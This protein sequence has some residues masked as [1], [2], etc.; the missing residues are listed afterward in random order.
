MKIGITEYGDAGLDFRWENKLSSVDGAVLITK[1][2]NQTFMNKVLAHKEVP[3][4]IHCTCTGW[5]G[6]ILEL[7]VPDYKTQLDNLRK[8]IDAG[9][10][11][12]RVVLRID[13]IF[14]AKE[15][16]EHVH[17]ML[18]YFRSLGL[19]EDKIRYRMSIVDEYNHVK[20]RYYRLGIRPLYPGFQASLAQR[21]MVAK[22]L[23]KYPYRFGTCAEDYLAKNYPDTFYVSGCISQE[24]LNLMGISA[25]ESMYENPQRRTGCHC[26]SCK[27]ELLDPRKKCGH[28]C[29]YCFWKDK[30]E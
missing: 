2:M 26:L 24:D 20:E 17:D 25:D 5:G 12:E 30:E 29:A 23:M 13:P 22:E 19:P 11:A 10:P 15:G 28:E 3:I 21:D 4:I 6:T 27:T 9:F 8:L 14:P 7:C 18:L 16:M 1:N